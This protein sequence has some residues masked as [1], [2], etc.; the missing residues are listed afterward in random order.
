MIN[1]LFNYNSIAAQSLS[2]EIATW[3]TAIS[4]FLMM[5]ATC[6]MAFYARKALGSWEKEIEY[7]FISDLRKD[8]IK[9]LS[10]LYFSLNLHANYY[11]TS[12]NTLMKNTN[13]FNYEEERIRIDKEFA[14]KQRNVSK[15]SY[16]YILYRPDNRIYLENLKNKLNEYSNNVLELINIRIQ[17][18]QSRKNGEPADFPKENEVKEKIK[19]NQATCE[20]LINQMKE[21]I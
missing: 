6:F 21:I 19:D 2:S 17:I 9:A 11:A 8:L 3:I 1:A 12:D 16:S 15:T 7:Q 13:D 14:S 20:K 18:L 4:T 10:D 5:V